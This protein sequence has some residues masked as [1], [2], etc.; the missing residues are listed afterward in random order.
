MRRTRSPVET[1]LHTFTITKMLTTY[2][3]S[4]LYIFYLQRKR[5]LSLLYLLS[6]KI[7]IC[8][9]SKELPLKYSIPSVNE[10]HLPSTLISSV[11]ENTTP[12]Y[13]LYLLSIECIHCQTLLFGCITSRYQTLLFGCI[14][15]S[16]PNTPV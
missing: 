4:N 12:S 1:A 15:N 11:N 5:S 6:M 7:F 3:T 14:T 13:T 16:L 10:K 2:S 9:P 8:C